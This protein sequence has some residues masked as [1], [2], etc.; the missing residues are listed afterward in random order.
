M[1][2]IRLS[3]RRSNQH[4]A[5]N[6][7]LAQSRL[8]RTVTSPV[9]KRIGQWHARIAVLRG[10]AERREAQRQLELAEQVDELARIIAEQQRTFD[11]EIAGLS[12]DIA[13]HDRIHDARKALQS[14]SEAVENIRRILR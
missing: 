6:A 1:A 8:A 2:V 11:R 13:A 9:T 12:S 5:P 14:S 3:M 10:L 4:R 7:Y